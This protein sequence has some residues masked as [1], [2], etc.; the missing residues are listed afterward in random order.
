MEGQLA[1][2]S[3]AYKAAF[4]KAHGYSLTYTPFVVSHLEM[5]CVVDP[6][7]EVE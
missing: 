5:G 6:V 1:S 2:M 4:E 3:G 7:D